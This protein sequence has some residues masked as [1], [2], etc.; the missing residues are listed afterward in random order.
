MGDLRAGDATRI[1]NTDADTWSA[2]AGLAWFGER[3]NVALA[4]RGQDFDYGVPAPD[5]AAV[6]IAGDR[7]ALQLRGDFAPTLSWLPSVRVDATTQRYAH[8]EV[9]PGGVVGTRLQLATQTLTVTGRT[10]VGA[11]RGTVGVQG[12]FRRYAGL[13]DET[14]TPAAR[15]D[16]VALLLHQ[17]LAVGPA[18]ADDRRATVQLGARHDWIRIVPRA[19]DDPRFASLTRRTVGT[20]SG[21]LGLSLPLPASTS[22]G[23]SVARAFRA[24]TVEELWSN[25]Y[26]AAVNSFDIGTPT[27][28]PELATGADLVL[29]MQRRRAF[30]QLAAYGTRIDG[31]VLPLVGADTTLADFGTVPI[32][33]FGQVNATLAGVELSGEAAL[34]RR[35]VLGVLADAVR[36]RGPD[37]TA[38]PFMPA[39]RVGG[40]LRWDAGRWLVGGD[41]RHVLAQT[42]VAADNPLAVRNPLDVATGAYT[43]LNL[44]GALTL[45]G[46]RTAHV[47]TLR[48]DN[49]LDVR[50]VD[51]TSRIKS[52]GWNPGRNVALG[53]R[54]GF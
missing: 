20:T 38:L 23:L 42:R 22:L 24:P 35:L 11:L 41:V 12:F 43:L 7:R 1:A 5:A 15:N 53:Y 54:L 13:G 27:L 44:N 40:S 14:F 10:Q 49:L 46:R 29:R 9:E 30:A 36:G 51:A 31:Y 28:R 33:R 2:S 4:V 26:H 32:V 34:H 39:A 17:E 45:P 48:I 3:A 50:Y 19:T 37:G 6:R 47:L 16:N 8:D 18:R 52:F 25:G 21:S